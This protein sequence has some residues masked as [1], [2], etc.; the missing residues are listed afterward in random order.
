[1]KRMIKATEVQNN[2]LDQNFYCNYAVTNSDWEAEAQ[3]AL[4]SVGGVKAYLALRDSQR[5]YDSNWYYL[6]PSMNAAGE[7]DEILHTKGLDEFVK[8]SNLNPIKGF[9]DDGKTMVVY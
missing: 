5:Q 3:V 7:F 4:E 8:L 9:D 1:M 6:F 2:I